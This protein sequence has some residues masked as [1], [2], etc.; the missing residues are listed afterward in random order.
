MD[1]SPSPPISV[2]SLQSCW[3]TSSLELGELSD[4]DSELSQDEN[5]SI[6]GFSDEPE[7]EMNVESDMWSEGTSLDEAF[8]REAASSGMSFDVL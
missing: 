6:S 5:E 1:R 3:N 8:E 7:T 2:S 4:S